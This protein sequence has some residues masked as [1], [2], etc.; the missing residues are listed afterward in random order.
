MFFNLPYLA[1]FVPYNIVPIN[2]LYAWSNNQKIHILFHKIAELVKATNDYDKIFE[3]IKGML[4]DFDDEMKRQLTALLEAM[5]EDGSLQDLIGQ[6]VSERLS[7]ALSTPEFCVDVSREFRIALEKYSYNATAF[8][9]E[10]YSYCQGGCVT[11]NWYN[12]TN[13]NSKYFIG[14]FVCGNGSTHQYNDNL[15]LRVY[16]WNSHYNTFSF[17]K[18]KKVSANHGN[19]IAVDI[20]NECIY[21]APSMKYD[22]GTTLVPCNLLFKYDFDLNEIGV[23]KINELQKCSNVAVYNGDVYVS[24]DGNTLNIKK[25]I[26][27]GSQ[28]DGAIVE[29]FATLTVEAPQT[30]SYGLSG[31]GL[32]ITDD[33]IF[34]GRGVPNGVYRFN[35]NNDNKLDCFYNIGQFGNSHTFPIG[36]VECISC[37][38]DTIYVN[39]IQNSNNVLSYYNYTQVFSFNYV[40]NEKLPNRLYQADAS[41]YRVIHV[42]DSTSDESVRAEYREISNPNGLA[43]MPFPLITEALMYANAQDIYTHLEL[44]C[45]TQNLVEYVVVMSNKFIK[46]SGED[47]YNSHSGRDDINERYVHLGGFYINGSNV[48]LSVVQIENRTPISLSDSLSKY[49]IYAIDSVININSNTKFHITGRS[50]DS[51]LLYCNR[52][53]GNIGTMLGNTGNNVTFKYNTVDNEND[54]CLLYNSMINFHGHIASDAGRSVNSAVVTYTQPNS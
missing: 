28:E 49:Q 32:A 22:G 24:Q 21:V 17:V 46:I 43:N 54:N 18:N 12:P 33:F 44:K 31:D 39:T 13:P 5:Y 10:K 52:T 20:E 7:S 41:S 1:A 25:I 50:A 26:S 15:D 27:W 42:G 11:K 30:N 23:T 4:D 16:E 19:S 2:E 38:D 29:D 35:R 9:E 34:V 37:V 40:N 14:A 48:T 47:F 6:V 53:T 45:I 36:E 8:T 3:E 51:Q